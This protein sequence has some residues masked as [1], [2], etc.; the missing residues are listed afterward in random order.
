MSTPLDG[1]AE[2]RT[3]A[4]RGDLHAVE[5]LLRDDP[6][7]RFA[8][9]ADPAA[10]N[11]TAWA[12][13]DRF[14]A[15][16]DPD[17]VDAAMAAFFAALHRAGHR[18]VV[19]VDHTTTG[20]SLWLGLPTGEVQD[21]AR[22]TLAPRTVLRSAQPTL[23][24]AAAGAAVRFR[25]GP[26]CPDAPAVHGVTSLV[27][28]LAAVAGGRWW[29]VADCLPAGEARRAQA[30]AEIVGAHR[31]VARHVSVT[32]DRTETE[33]Q[34]VTDPSAQ[35][36][37][38]WLDRITAAGDA[39]AER[40]GWSVEL[41]VGGD[42][43]TTVWAV[44]SAVAAEPPGP[45]DRA[46]R[47]I[48]D[49]VA[50]HPRGQGF[51]SALDSTQLAAWLRPPT[52][53]RG[54]VGV[55]PALPPGRVALPTT[56]R[57]ELGTWLGTDEPAALDVSD[58]AGHAFLTGTT[59]SG[60]STT[61]ARLLTA[62]WNAHGI[63]FLVVDPVK[64]DYSEL[65][66][67][68]R[69]GLTL[70][71]GGQLRMSALRP[72]PGFDPAT[73]L[74]YVAAAFKGAFSMPS[75][76]PYVTTLLFDR[77][78]E[79]AA[80]GELTLHDLRRAVGP[81]LDELGYRGEL[82]A[83]IRASLGTRLA[84]LCAPH[85]AERLCAPDVNALLPLWDQPTVVTL[86]DIG[87]DEERAFLMALLVLY[88]AERAKTRGVGGLAHLTAIE[89]A[90]RL[91]GQPAQGGPSQEHGDAAG[92]AARLVTQLLAEIR[93]V[94]ESMFIVDQSPAA[95]ARDV[96]RNTNVKIVH[97][98]LDP[99]D[100]ELCAGAMGLDADDSAFL[101]QLGPGQ[102]AV[103]A[104]RLPAPQVVAIREV[105]RP[106][107]GRPPA[108]PPAATG[109]PCCGNDA[110]AHHRAEVV[111]DHAGHT[112]R[113]VLV[114]ACVTGHAAPEH[115]AGLDRIAARHPGTGV[116]CLRR[117]GVRSALRTWTD[118]GRVGTDEIPALIDRVDRDLR[119][120]GPGV[121]ADTLP[122][123][124]RL[125]AASR[126]F[127]GCAPCRVACLVRPLAVDGPDVTAARAELGRVPR[128][129]RV[130]AA[131]Q[132]SHDYLLAHED[133]LTTRVAAAAARCVLLHALGDDSF[134]PPGGGRG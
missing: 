56:R 93:S 82:E 120:G 84:V 6:H 131:E 70:V 86:G 94:G 122:A 31:D 15:T 27:E 54:A 2:L 77:V 69:G 48:S 100:R 37:A 10:L 88:V 87:D 26:A 83:N 25:V 125:A 11:T 35:R 42:D 76:V 104:A 110:L 134:P 41:R 80:G 96:V 36:L 68:L 75:P 111:A 24:T 126:P 79:S 16:D 57:V 7:A 109:R 66:G 29:V 78:R 32:L 123:G 60:K 21:W 39:M 19:A 133:L 44:A 5:S 119:P 105:L 97:R 95:V 98:V 81:L 30:T 12:V 46:G 132:W 103:A 64:V 22:R 113:R 85:R 8:A 99:A 72:W 67:V 9:P 62:A 117:I 121:T 4:H 43:P 38:C 14:T 65:A 51:V 129:E 49:V 63:P 52:A 90:H 61:L 73:H 34:Q 53:G 18:V 20:I 115:L 102:A 3:A 40:G 124:M 59:G 114:R 1:I 106:G 101:A 28:R 128:A 127:A 13:V 71:T 92:H 50:V 33:S 89:E 23:A 130:D 47:W 74:G 17:G 58:L 116:D 55:G 108:P 107:A 118:L 112:L 45:A 91:V